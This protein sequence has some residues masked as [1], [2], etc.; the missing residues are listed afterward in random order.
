MVPQSP[1]WAEVSPGV[2]HWGGPSLCHRDLPRSGCGPGSG[3]CLLLF[4]GCP[5]L[6]SHIPLAGLGEAVMPYLHCSLRPQPHPVPRDARTIHSSGQ[7]F[8]QLRQGCLQSGTLFEDPDFP[9][10]NGSLFYSERPQVPFVWK[11]PGVS[12][13]RKRKRNRER[14]GR[15]R[16]EDGGE[17]ERALK[18]V[19]GK[20]ITRKPIFCLLWE[21]LW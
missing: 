20:G 21:A 2:C 7:T 8:E 13:V 17:G 10:T 6:A 3:F 9:A 1:E 15:D 14:R 11:R 18:G 12:R 4:A 16:D 5:C 19:K